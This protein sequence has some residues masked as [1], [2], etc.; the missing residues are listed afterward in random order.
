MC[1]DTQPHTRTHRDTHTHTHPTLKAYA[2]SSLC[3]LEFLE[4]VLGYYF[5]FLISGSSKCLSTYTHQSYQWTYGFHVCVLPAPGLF[6]Q[7]CSFSHCLLNIWKRLVDIIAHGAL[8][9]QLLRDAIFP[10]PRTCKPA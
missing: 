10:H 6:T 2:E 3:M 1:Q 8:W 7:L 5:I 9:P 4:P